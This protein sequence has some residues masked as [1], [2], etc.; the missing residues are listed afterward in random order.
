LSVKTPLNPGIPLTDITFFSDFVHSSISWHL[1]SICPKLYNLLVGWKLKQYLISSQIEQL[2]IIHVWK[3]R[4]TDC[5]SVCP[6]MFLFLF[7]ANWQTWNNHIN[8]KML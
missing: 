4:Y 5:L 2:Y 6:S 8:T 3:K 7:T 1:N